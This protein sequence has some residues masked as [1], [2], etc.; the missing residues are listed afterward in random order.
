MQRRDEL[1]QESV[2]LNKLCFDKDITPSESF[3]IKEKQNEVYQKY[4]WVDNF[5]KAERKIKK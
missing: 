5:I 4:K 2:M 1:I 3:R